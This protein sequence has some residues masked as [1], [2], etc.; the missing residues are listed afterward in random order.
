MAVTETRLLSWKIWCLTNCLFTCKQWSKPSSWY[1][2]TSSSKI[3][4]GIL[5][6]RSSSYNQIKISRSWVFL[7]KH[8][9]L[10][11][12]SGFMTIAS[13]THLKGGKCRTV[14][15][16]SEQVNWALNFHILMN[17]EKNLFSEAVTLGV[18]VFNWPSNVQPV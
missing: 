12:K 15:K 14:L 16:D 10:W 3:C 6:F 8:C 4:T 5:K 18:R 1:W 17:Q 2:N 9:W 7:L 13:Q 11:F